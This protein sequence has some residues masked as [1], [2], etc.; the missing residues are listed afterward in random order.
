MTCRSAS[1]S[2]YVLRSSPFNTYGS[3]NERSGSS[4]QSNSTINLRGLGDARTLVLVNSKRIP[5]SPNLGA[6]SVNINMLPQ[7][8]IARTELLAD[9]ASTVYG[10][11]AI[12]GVVNNI[13]YEEYEGLTLSISGAD[14]DRDESGESGFGFI[15][16]LSTDKAKL[17]VALEVNERDP[18]FDAD[19]P[20][21]SAQVRDTNGD[22]IFSFR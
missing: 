4:A 17:V 7:I 15:T 19:R 11:D 13:T 20:Y 3:F 16:G 22:G 14:R 10:S 12:A 21:T 8:A 2:E 6:A 18:I 5:G 1:A 9:G